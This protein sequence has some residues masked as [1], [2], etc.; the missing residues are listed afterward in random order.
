M[1]HL[2]AYFLT[3]QKRYDAAL[4]QFR[5]VD[6]HVGALPWKYW[7]DPAEAFC[8]WRDRAAHRAR[9]R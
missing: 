7:S 6:G 3:R 2:L 4:A 9:R 5:L 8:H 1:R